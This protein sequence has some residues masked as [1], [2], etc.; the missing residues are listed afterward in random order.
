MK[1][2]ACRNFLEAYI[3]GEL[4][5]PEAAQVNAHLI[6][7]VRCAG[8]FDELAA[9]Q[10]I[11]ARYD[12]A[13]NI[14]PVMWPAIAARTDPVSS[15]VEATT[16]WRDRISGFFSTRSAGWSLASATLVLLVTAVIGVAYLQMHRRGTKPDVSVT[17]K[18]EDPSVAVEKHDPMQTSRASAD[19]KAAIENPVRKQIRLKTISR[20]KARMP[21]NAGANQ[22][23][24]LFTDVAY[25]AAE[26]EETQK[27]LEQAQNLLRSVRNIEFSEDDT[28]VDVSYEKALSRQLLNENVVLRRDA[29]MSG[30]FPVKTLL[31]SLE[32]F[33]LDIANLPDKTSP[34]DLRVIKDRVEKTEIVAALHSY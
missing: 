4:A 5:E 7:C 16:G 23:D 17:V 2:E 26:E 12:R 33:L 34:D 1:C 20:T 28:E 30:K 24:V 27:H 14:S 3:D 8:D 21:L 25:S 6:T 18:R 19:D 29:E 32:P 15:P 22:S 9:E 31:S 13:L 10:E 11:Y